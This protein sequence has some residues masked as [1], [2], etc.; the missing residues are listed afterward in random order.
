LVKWSEM[1][2]KVD[3]RNQRVPKIVTGLVNKT[4]VSYKLQKLVWR[5]VKK[6]DGSLKVED[7]HIEHPANPDHGDYSSNIAMAIF[8]HLASHI[9]NLKSPLDLAKKI[10]EEIPKVNYLQKI[11]AVPPGFINLWLS[12][13]FLLES[14]KKSVDL[15]EK[16]GSGQVLKGK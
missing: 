3:K 15:R 5:A 9:S 16:Y 6:L 4:G 12:K 2:F 11:E 1:K 14:L 8:S 7:V 10:V 13:E